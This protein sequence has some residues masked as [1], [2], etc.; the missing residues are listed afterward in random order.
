MLINIKGWSGWKHRLG[1]YDTCFMCFRNALRP[2]ETSWVEKTACVAGREQD[3]ERNKEQS[4]SWDFQRFQWWF[5]HPFSLSGPC[6]C[7]CRNQEDILEES[8]SAV[9]RSFSLGVT[10]EGAVQR[11]WTNIWVPLVLLCTTSP[12]SLAQVFSGNSVPTQLLKNLVAPPRGQCWTLGAGR[13][14]G[15]WNKEVLGVGECRVSFHC[16]GEEYAGLSMGNTS[17]RGNTAWEM[18]LSPLNSVSNIF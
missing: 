5:P 6:N 12:S 14:G 13:G 17:T 18:G 8:D 11:C 7:R 16:A 1:D 15:R 4:S 10:K 2:C 9:W 3:E